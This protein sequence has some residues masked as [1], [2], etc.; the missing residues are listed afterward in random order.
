MASRIA[1]V[2]LAAC[3]ACGGGGNQ[4]FAT[5]SASISGPIG[6]QTMTP[7]DAVSAVVQN[8]SNA[9]GEIVITNFDS[10]CAKFNKQQEPRNTQAIIIGLGNRSSMTAIVAPSTTGPYPVYTVTDSRNHVGV[11]A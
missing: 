9:A 5:G 1:V 3:A 6:G 10:A 7:K 2:V 4:T 8:G 11:Q